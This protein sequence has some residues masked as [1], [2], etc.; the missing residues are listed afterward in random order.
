MLV[1]AVLVAALC[2]SIALASTPLPYL[3]GTIADTHNSA[4]GPRAAAVASRRAGLLQDDDLWLAP[5]ASLAPSQSG[6]TAGN[7]DPL[8]SVDA[9]LEGIAYSMVDGY[10]QG[11]VS[12]TILRQLSD[13][14]VV[15]VDAAVLDVHSYHGQHVK[16]AVRR[17]QPSATRGSFARS[18]A[19]NSSADM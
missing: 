4:G 8:A 5:T 7:V 19:M 9:V 15:E 13:D 17:A 10:D 18:S 12:Y 6:R 16:W 3:R 2:V 11:S 14:S 1:A